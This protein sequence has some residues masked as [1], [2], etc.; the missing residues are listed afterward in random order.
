V[1]GPSERLVQRLADL[2]A[3]H[4]IEVSV[5]RPGRV[6]AVPIERAG[7]TDRRHLYVLG[8]D[9]GSFPG[10]A[11][12]DPVLLDDERL[13]L[14]PQ[15]A[16]QRSRPGER[17]WNLVRALGMASGEVT[18][19]A[20]CWSLTDS[21]EIYP[22]AL[23]HQ[24]AVQLQ[25]DKPVSTLPIVPQPE[26]ALDDGE[27]M[28]G[29]RKAAGFRE[30]AAAAFP[31]L[32]RGQQAV[33]GRLQPGFSRFH[34]CLGRGTPAIADGCTVL[35]AS[36]LETLAAC[37]YRYFLRYVL[38]VDPPEI[39]EEDSTRWLTPLEFGA[40]LHHL[41]YCFMRTLQDRREFPDPQRHHDLIEEMLQEQIDHYRER[42]PVAHEAAYRADCD[43]LRQA[44]RIFLAAEAE[45]RGI[46]PIGFEVSF[47]FGQVGVLS[48]AEAVRLRLSDQ[49]QLAL[50]GRIDRVDRVAN[51]Y[52][53]WDY[54][55]GS[56]WGYDEQNLLGGGLR[57][58]WALYAYALEE[59]LQKG[60]IVKSG[61]FF[62]GERGDGRRM[63]D[64]PPEREKV[65]E[66]LAPLLELVSR[67][68][69]F[70]VHK[71]G[72][73]CM[74]CDYNRICSAENSVKSSKDLE[75]IAPERCT[76][77]ACLKRWLDG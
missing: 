48:R 56:V 23:F 68:C 60:Q 75:G 2:I 65:A 50:R 6:Y 9:E 19:L 11:T 4:R 40:L 10:G 45:R 57:L 31:W 8:M 35:S 28:L 30:A 32:G 77:V 25:C 22:C 21:R 64:V 76:I 62:P 20:A 15:L 7:Y 66:L 12:E 37:P 55:T 3:R 52:E 67:G 36:R 71:G 42:I 13:S 27:A 14:S 58:Q 54:K 29:V 53:I 59:T 46:E 61:Y 63:G 33:Q 1:K 16:L 47:G 44:S 70:H 34:G 38:M 18:L 51:G 43:R 73:P 41:F 49:V 5:A 74:Y 17:V 39:H 72:S 24:A 69:F 26:D